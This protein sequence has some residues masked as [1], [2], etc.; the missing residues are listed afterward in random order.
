[1]TTHE[2]ELIQG[3]NIK[4]TA[5]KVWGWE[6][7]AGK[8][9][10]NKRFEVYKEAIGGKNKI[11]EIGCGTGLMTKK[12]SDYG[13]NV[14]ALDI[15]PELLEK[16]KTRVNNKNTIFV[17]A[18]V[19]TMPFESNSFEA[20]IGVSV[21]HHTRIDEV[22]KEIKRVLLPGGRILFSEPNMM[23]PQIFIMKNSRL[24]GNIMNEVPGETAFTRGKLKKI[25]EKAG[26][27]EVSIKPF[28]FIHPSVPGL[29]LNIFAT[30]SIVLE[31]IFLIKEIAGSLLISGYKQQ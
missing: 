18:D 30:I 5:E 9:R 8:V 2:D 14:T 7:P 24:I 17:C 1:M 31:K 10:L 16:A 22:L 20:V 27:S 21:L 29:F 12:L 6:T 25:I 15:S 26:F 13:F 28:D 23:N 4:D 3:R 19:H 11:L